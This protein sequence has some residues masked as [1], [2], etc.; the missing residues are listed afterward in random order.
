MDTDDVIAAVKPLARRRSLWTRVM[1]LAR[2][3]A[4]PLASL[5][6]VYYGV[7][8]IVYCVERFLVFS[9]TA[10]PTTPLRAT[11]L[12]MLRSKA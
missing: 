10:L 3:A 11:S 4:A 9:A 7:S 5:L 2:I 1:S 12:Y 6:L 8:Y